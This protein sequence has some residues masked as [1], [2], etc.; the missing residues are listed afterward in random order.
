MRDLEK[1]V[2]VSKAGRVR[3]CY[4]RV[5]GRSKEKLGGDRWKLMVVG[6]AMVFSD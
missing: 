4:E 1:S 6:K 3:G 5:A 2:I